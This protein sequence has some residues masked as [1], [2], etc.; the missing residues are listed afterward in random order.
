MA[1][2]S[3]YTV[4][5]MMFVYEMFYWNKVSFAKVTLRKVLIN[6]ATWQSCI[7]VES[8]LMI[9]NEFLP[10][11]F[12]SLPCSSD[13]IID[14]LVGCS[15]ADIR[16]AALEQ[17]FLLSQTECTAQRTP[18]HFMLQLLLK[19][20]VPFWVSSASAR[21]VSQRSVCRVNIKQN[22]RCI[23]DIGG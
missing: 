6:Y 13:F 20:Y 2:K 10:A 14:I 11:S 18:H 15:N 3:P 21:G 19:A 5:V 9:W 16:N 1:L 7:N 4:H 12:Y 23:Q 22:Y 17:F 8:C